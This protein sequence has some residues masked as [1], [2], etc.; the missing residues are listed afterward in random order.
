MTSRVLERHHPEGRFGPGLEYFSPRFT[1]PLT[2]EMHDRIH[3]SL[4]AAR[5]EFPE[6]PGPYTEYLIKR[7]RLQL[8]LLADG[9]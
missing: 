2:K 5:L 8:Q 1:I 3:V 6:R 9:R 4:R 7:L